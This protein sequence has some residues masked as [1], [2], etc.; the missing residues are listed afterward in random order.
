MSCT[1]ARNPRLDH[2]AIFGAACISQKP[3]QEK[4][5]V[6]EERARLGILLGNAEKYNDAYV[7]Y[8]LKTGRIVISKDVRID[9]N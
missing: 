7:V 6:L 8:S 5:T 1:K 2:I 4:L 9:E 3:N